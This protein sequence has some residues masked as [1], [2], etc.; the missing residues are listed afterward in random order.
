MKCVLVVV[1]HFTRDSQAY[2]ERNKSSRTVA[3]KMYDD[4][5][6]WFEYPAKI[7]HD[8]G[9]EFEDDIFRHL[10]QL[11]NISHFRTTRYHPQGNGQVERYN[12]SYHIIE[13][14]NH[15]RIQDIK[16]ERLPQ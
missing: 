3:S 9:K 8:Q 15:P 4:L 2:A 6:L 5:I 14:C 7:H 11:C 13:A 1:D 16:A 12:Q 10:E